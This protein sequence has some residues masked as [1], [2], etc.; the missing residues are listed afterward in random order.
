MA[1][2]N[3]LAK[4]IDGDELGNGQFANRNNQLGLDNV[5][6][7]AKP[8]MAITDFL[9]C[10]HAVTIFQ[11]DAIFK[12]AWKAATNSRHIDMLSKP[13]FLKADLLKPFKESFACCPCK[14]F[15]YLNFLKAGCLADEHYRG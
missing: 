8:L 13:V 1:V 10:G 15:M 12:F 2:T 11:G 7:P 6:F 4:F 5:Y 14:R 3:N 9:L